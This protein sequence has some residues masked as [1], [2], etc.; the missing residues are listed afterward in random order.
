MMRMM[1]QVSPWV[2]R[3]CVFLPF[4]F[5]AFLPLSAQT[6]TQKVQQSKQ[7]EGSV[8]I[9]HDAAIDEL[10]NARQAVRSA[11]TPSPVTPKKDKEDKPANTHHQK[12]DTTQQVSKPV[13]DLDTAVVVT[14]RPFK[15]NGYRVQVFAGGNT[16]RDKLKAEQIGRSLEQLFPNETVYVHFYSP[17]WICRI[18]NYR[19]REEANAKMIEIRQLGYNSASV[20]P[21]KIIV[22]ATQ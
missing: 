10:V 11:P 15:T 20:V 13:H 22:F 7:G 3:L 18:G 4:Y 12:T 6:F 2:K 8:T 9:H 14:G 17:R 1:K 16:R 19:T 5:F 21:G